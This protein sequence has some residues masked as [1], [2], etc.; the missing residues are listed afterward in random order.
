MSSSTP[1]SHFLRETW[2][3][4]VVLFWRVGR[5]SVCGLCLS[6]QLHCVAV[7]WSSATTWSVPHRRTAELSLVLT[8][9]YCKRC[10]R[11]EMNIFFLI[12]RSENLLH[13][14]DYLLDG[15]LNEKGVVV[16]MLNTAFT[17]FCVFLWACVAHLTF[18]CC[19]SF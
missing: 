8:Q 18:P 2:G 16:S 15:I 1:A 17:S 7:S 11:N 12:Y 6:A 5:V 3:L 14:S 4:K 19:N 9:I 10:I 13:S